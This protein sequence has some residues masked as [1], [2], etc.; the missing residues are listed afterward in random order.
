MSYTIESYKK[1]FKWLKDFG[2]SLLISMYKSYD[3]LNPDDA[4]DNDN[5]PDF[6]DD[7]QSWYSEAKHLIKQ[8]LPDR[9]DDF[10]RLYELPRSRDII[11]PVGYSI[12]DCLLGNVTFN[13]KGTVVTGQM[14]AIRNFQQQ[15]SIV[16][17]LQRRFESS[18]FDIRLH[19]QAEMFDDEL[20][21]A[22]Y[23]LKNRFL[24]AAGA[25]AGVVL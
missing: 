21:A 8:L 13:G 22:L 9:L 12:E 5:L 24:R 7:Y 23:L 3:D 6:E 4:G 10:Q 14:N 1:D 17:G 25:M 15:L 11:N 16:K 20:E 19:M 2:E 18:L